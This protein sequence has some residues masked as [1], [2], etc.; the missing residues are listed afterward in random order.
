MKKVSRAPGQALADFYIF[1]L[2][3]EAWGCGDLFRRWENPEATFRILQECTKGT[4]CDITGI[5]GYD[6]IEALRGIQWPLPEGQRVEAMSQRRL[7]E[8]GIFYRP[9]GKAKLW[10]ESSREVDEPTDKR[11]PF[12]LLSGRGSSSQWHTQTR[13]SKSD[14]LRKLY[15]AEP[16]VEISPVD[17][18][19]L[20]IAQ[21]DWVRVE[22]RRGRMKAR[23]FITNVV[24]PG[25]VFVPMHYSKMNRLTFPAFDPYSR[26]PSY[27]HCA[28]RIRAEDSI[29]GS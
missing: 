9:N 1:K 16:Y 26:Q 10:F 18:R 5:N 29:P 24:Q 8:D 12:I 20:D 4:P 21:N 19:A 2:I 27:K 25:Q 22:S 11:Y 28:V 7:F 13:T 23:A 3:A 6:D 17:A 14:V 15:S